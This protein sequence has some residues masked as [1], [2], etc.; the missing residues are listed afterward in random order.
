MSSFEIKGVDE[1][2]E[3]LKLI[4]KKA[5][6]RI[7]D[8]LDEEGKELRKKARANTPKVGGRLRKGYKLLK[9]EKIKGGYQKGMTNTAPHFHLVEKG[10]R[11]VSK[12][13]KELGFTPGVH[14]LEKT[15][16]EMESPLMNELKKWLNEV[17]K[18]LS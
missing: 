15:V 1:F 6:D 13:G 7:L 9:V 8:K 2:Q 18:E 12:A 11:K 4:E 10:H 14:M 3:K 5:P 16:K 17:F